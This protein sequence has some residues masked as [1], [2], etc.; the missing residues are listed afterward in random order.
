MKYNKDD[1]YKTI[2]FFEYDARNIVLHV[3]DEFNK[4]SMNLEKL[5]AL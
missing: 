5:I 1:M 4:I 3:F 2:W